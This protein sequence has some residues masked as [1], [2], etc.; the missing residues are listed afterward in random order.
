M[1]INR[2]RCPHFR[3]I[4]A[5][6][7]SHGG[8]DPRA[9]RIPIFTPVSSPQM[10]INRLPVWVLYERLCVLYERP[11]YSAEMGEKPAANPCTMSPVPF[12]P[13]HG[14]E[15]RVDV[16]GVWWVLTLPLTWGRNAEDRAPDT[17]VSPRKGCSTSGMFPGS[18][19]IPATLSSATWFGWLGG[20]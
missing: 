7:P 5:F 9:T 18:R 4:S 6:L 16:L 20:C 15:T 12:L 8:I 1:G 3:R 13:S 10:G 2:N 17:A 19:N 14:G 11:P